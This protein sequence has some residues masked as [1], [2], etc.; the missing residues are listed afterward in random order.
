[1]PQPRLAERAN[2][3][4]RAPDRV[5]TE[6]NR[7]FQMEQHSGHY[8]TMWCGV[9]EA[10]TRTLRYACAGAPPALAFNAV[11]GQAP[12]MTELSTDSVPIGI[13]EDTVYTSA[14][15]C[16]PPGC[17]MLLYSDGA[18]ELE[19][20]DGRRFAME[21]FKNLATRLASSPNGSIDDL[22]EELRALTPAGGFVDD[23]SL[24]GLRFD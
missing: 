22:V 4:L 6:L 17:R 11:T 24:I 1:M 16:V 19:P 15:Y 8:F 20:P 10:S 14:T 9:Y 2:E 5:L 13:F 7:L 18:C 3:I 21:D 23:C 12:A